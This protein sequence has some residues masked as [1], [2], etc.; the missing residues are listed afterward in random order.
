MSAAAEVVAPAKVD[1]RKLRGKF[2][3]LH[4]PSLE[5]VRPVRAARWVTRGGAPPE[6]LRFYIRRG[7]GHGFHDE[8]QG[9]PELRGRSR[10]IV[11][12]VAY[13]MWLEGAT[14]E[15]IARDFGWPK[16]LVVSQLQHARRTMTTLKVVHEAVAKL[17][18]V[19]IPLA[20]DA[21]IGALEKGDVDA[22]FKLLTGRQ[23]FVKPNASGDE[24]VRGGDAGGGPVF[25]GVQV[26]I[27]HQNGKATTLGTVVGEPLTG[28]ALPV[29]TAIDAST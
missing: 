15:K 16:S 29:D 20:V 10:R 28:E 18:R 3:I 12:T 5:L 7:V 2:A 27:I 17:D 9:M 25:Q 22:G 19:G 1:R 14:I 23:V 21:I 8:S 4:R 13:A 6:G 26:N 24:P 11:R